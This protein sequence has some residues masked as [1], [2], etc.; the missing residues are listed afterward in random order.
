[1]AAARRASNVSRASLSPDDTQPS[2]PLARK[3]STIR[4]FDSPGRFPRVA[5]RGVGGADRKA[6]EEIIVRRD[7][8]P[9]SISDKVRSRHSSAISERWMRF[10][11]PALSLFRTGIVWFRYSTDA[12][13][14]RGRRAFALGAATFPTIDIS[15]DNSET[16]APS[17]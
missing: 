9:A 6:S 8:R 11:L 14:A 2:D 16:Y 7:S 15:A 10:T 12:R 13:A 3:S 4:I 17:R 1:M 5:Y